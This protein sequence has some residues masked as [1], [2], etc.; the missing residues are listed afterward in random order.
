MGD[1]GL[2]Y[3]ASGGLQASGGLWAPGGRNG[4]ANVPAYYAGCVLDIFSEYSLKIPRIYS[5]ILDISLSGWHGDL[6]GEA[7]GWAGEQAHRQP[8]EDP[9]NLLGPRF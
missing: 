8:W 6:T 7:G 1:P 4:R 2:S 3:W 9:R 5:N